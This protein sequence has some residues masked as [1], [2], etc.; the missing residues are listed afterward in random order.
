MSTLLSILESTILSLVIIISLALNSLI[1]YVIFSRRW[2]DLKGPDILITNL[3]VCHGLIAL[4]IMPF[5]LAT[6]VSEEH[7]R[8]AWSSSKGLCMVRVTLFIWI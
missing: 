2:K 4:L 5:V 6:I 8:P 7:D 1:L 3:T